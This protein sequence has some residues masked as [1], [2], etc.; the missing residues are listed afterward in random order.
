MDTTAKSTATDP[1][2]RAASLLDQLT[3]AA[4]KAF[5][6]DL[7]SLVLFGSAA[8]GRL[9]ASSDINLLLVLERFDAVEVD[10]FRAPLRAAHAAARVQAMFMLRDELPAAAELFAV[11]FSDIRVRHRVLHGPDLVAGLVIPPEALYLRTREVLLNLVLR[12]RE[13]YTR[14]SLREEQLVQAIADT[15]GP[16]RAAAMAIL[17][18]EGRQ[19]AAP[20]AALESIV[21]DLADAELT[22]TLA[23]LSAARE[24]GALPPG[25][26]GPALLAL[27]RL[28]SILR[29]RL[30]AR[31]AG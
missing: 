27:T 14:V 2:D 19:A 8:E 3:Q 28:A 15:A 5:G 6:S 1:A 13:R 18:L 31:R 25:T 22:Q 26:A 7:V 29:G 10:A 9:R 20:K 16:L 30:E 12:L 17:Q 4:L 11:K 24:R 21:A 23:I